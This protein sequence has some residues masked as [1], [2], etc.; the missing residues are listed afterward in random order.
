MESQAA[1]PGAGGV[2]TFTGILDADTGT[3]QGVAAVGAL[4]AAEDDLITFNGLPGGPVVLTNSVPPATMFVNGHNGGAKSYDASAMAAVDGALFFPQ[5]IYGNEFSFNSP[6]SIELFFKTHG[7]QSGAGRMELVLQGETAFRY[8]II[9]NE[10]GPGSVR[11][12]LNNG[13]SIQLAD[14]SGANYADGQWHYLLAVYDPLSPPNGQM[15]LTL[16]NQAGTEVSTTNTLPTGFGPLP[17]G[18][19]GNLFLGRNTY[20]QALDSRTFGGLMD[21]VQITAGVVPDSWRL[22]RIPSMDSHLRISRVSLGTNG[23]NFQ[24]TGAA[25]NNFVVQWVARFG[26]AW[27]DIAIL[28]STDSSNGYLDT[29]TSRLTSSAGFYRILSQ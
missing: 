17:A 9:V 28:A 6:F 12:T 16:V 7:N 29:N 11:F 18:N 22:G 5:D 3:G 20:S 4:S 24:W 25:A 21:E 13:G 19:D 8:G 15:R 10:A 27:Q 23:V 1:A 2:P 26:D 14:L